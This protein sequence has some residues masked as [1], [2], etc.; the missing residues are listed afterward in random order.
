MS[1]DLI[2]DCLYGFLLA[3]TVREHLTIV[4]V[5]ASGIVLLH[6]SFK[7]KLN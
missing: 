7:L 3:S 1:S 5:Y 6:D 4:Y 2:S